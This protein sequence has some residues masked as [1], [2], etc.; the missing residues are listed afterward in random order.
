MGHGIVLKGIV[1]YYGRGKNI[2]HTFGHTVLMDGHTS[3][4]GPEF[5]DKCYEFGVVPFCLLPHTTHILQPLDVCVFL[6]YKHWHQFVM[7]RIVREGAF[8]FGKDDFLRA[9]PEINKLA[10]KKSTIR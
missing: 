2:P 6:P 10:F 3:H 8:T 5:I 1:K 4:I 7:E 9:L